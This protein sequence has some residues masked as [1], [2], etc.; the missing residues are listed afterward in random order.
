MYELVNPFTPSS[1]ASNPGMFYGRRDELK[2]LERSFIQA[3]VS[4]QGAVGIG[5]SSLL[6]QAI[7]LM[8]GFE[9]QHKSKAVLVTGHKEI[10]SADDLAR[11]ILE[12][13]VLFDESNNKIKISLLKVV[14]AES[15][16]IKRNFVAGR[17]LDVLTKLL[18]R[19]YIEQYMDD[20]EF[21]IIAID[22]ADKCP[23]AIARVV[24]VLS[25]NLQQSGVNSVRFMLAGVN[26]YFKAI[27]DEDPG[28][29]RFFVKPL[30]LSSFSEEEAEELL[31]SK[32]QLVVEECA[33]YGKEI[34]VSHDLV[35]HIVRLSGGH[36][37][38]L[39][40]LGFHLIEREEEDPDGV[41]DVKDLTNAL[42][43]ICYE[44]RV[45]I[46]DSMIHMLEVNGK[47]ESFRD[48][49]KAAPKTFPTT[50]PTDSIKRL[51]TNED[52]QWLFENNYIVLSSADTYGLADEFLRVRIIMDEQDSSEDD[53][54]KELLIYAPQRKMLDFGDDYNDEYVDEELLQGI[55]TEQYE[56]LWGYDP[57]LGEEDWDDD[58]DK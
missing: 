23:Q 40:L 50:W 54:E 8:E 19:E 49:I 48:L 25:N 33:R 26:P 21:L 46:Y 42:K 29:G 9:S 6:S 1:I 11:S 15:S 14:E 5:K 44:D 17:H 35:P 22:E 20:A 16:E 55:T 7:L 4:I 18:E 13:F 38:L 28:V 30:Q 41:L 3:S 53:I 34:E 12:K 51:F 27:T 39:Q 24:R 57:D 37:H 36:P 32:I 56:H 2:K 58:S 43:T 10:A 47:L 52:V 45:Y 31:T